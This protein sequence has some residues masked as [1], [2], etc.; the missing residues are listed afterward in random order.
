MTRKK[1]QCM[2]VYV[3]EREEL[4]ILDPGLK[5][6]KMMNFY[7]PKTLRKTKRTGTKA[8]F[9]TPRPYTW[10]QVEAYVQAILRAEGA[11]YPTVTLTPGVG[12]WARGKRNEI[13][14]PEWARV[15]TVMLHE[16][17]HTLN[18]RRNVRHDG[19]GPKFM[20]IFIDLLVKYMGYPESMLRN[21]ARRYGV[22]VA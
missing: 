4:F 16:I 20:K 15:Q 8:S 21:S 13:I 12:R 2:Q 14:L 19:H 18:Q 3:W 11:T 10:P 22:Q 17:A 6:V 9:E 7:S 5:Y 1:T